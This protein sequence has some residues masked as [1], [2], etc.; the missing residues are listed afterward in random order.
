MCQPWKSSIR[1]NNA[2]DSW[3]NVWSLLVARHPEIN[4]EAKGRK[5]T[6]PKKQD[7]LYPVAYSWF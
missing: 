5:Q 1:E 4:M 7:R 3:E 2:N 6:L